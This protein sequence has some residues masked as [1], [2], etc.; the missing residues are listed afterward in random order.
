MSML[1]PLEYNS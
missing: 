1:K